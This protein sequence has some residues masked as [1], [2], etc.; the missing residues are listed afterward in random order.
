VASRRWRVVAVF[1]CERGRVSER[2]REIERERVEPEK[3]HVSQKWKGAK[4][5]RKHSVLATSALAT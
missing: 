1:E 4:K 5:K 3:F 2:E